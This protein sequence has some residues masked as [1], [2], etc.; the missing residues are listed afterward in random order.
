MT[1][2]YFPVQTRTSRLLFPEKGSK[3]ASNRTSLRRC[4]IRVS[5]RSI[6][7]PLQTGQNPRLELVS[8]DSN[9]LGIEAKSI[10][11]NRSVSFLN[12]SIQIEIDGELIPFEGE[13][14]LTQRELFLSASDMKT[15]AM[16]PGDLVFVASKTARPTIFGDVIVRASDQS[17]FSIAEHEADTALLTKS[18]AVFVTAAA[19]GQ[20]TE[21]DAPPEIILPSRFLQISEKTN[22]L[23]TEA[24]V[25][26]AIL[27]NKKIWVSRQ[28]RLTPAARDLGKSRNVFE[29]EL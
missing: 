2:L 14:Q 1:L 29:F 24:H 15:L 21:D 27:K 25:W 8:S 19:A 3:P 6:E 7:V 10:L 9:T 23:I 18:D 12:L 17:Y 20:S 26:R 5:G 22:A 4:R 11:K 28:S 16:K 13:I